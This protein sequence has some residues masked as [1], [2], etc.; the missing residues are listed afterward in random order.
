M[1]D[2]DPCPNCK[3]KNAFPM[4][5]KTQRYNVPVHQKT[6]LF[7][8]HTE[9]GSDDYETLKAEV[10]ASGSDFMMKNVTK[11]P[12]YVTDAGAQTTV[13]PGASFKLKKSTTINFGA[14]GIEVV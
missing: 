11:D 2:A 6:K 12:V 7:A 3:K 10:A 9:K 8:C 14:V 13:A 5:I 1:P 4:Y